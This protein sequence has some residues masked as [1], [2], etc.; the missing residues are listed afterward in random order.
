MPRFC[1]RSTCTSCSTPFSTSATRD[2]IG[3]IL[4]RISSLM[5]LSLAR[6][7]GK[8]G[9]AYLQHSPATRNLLTVNRQRLPARNGKFFEQ[10][11]GFAEGQAHYRRIT[12]LQLADEHRRQPLNRVTAS[13]VLGLAA[14]PVGGDFL[15]AQRAKTH[16]AADH[17]HGHP[18][19]AGQGH[20]R[21]GTEYHGIQWLT[22]RSQAGL[23]FRPGQTLY[24]GDWRL[25]W[26]WIFINGDDLAKKGH[27]NL[28][29]QFTSTRR[30]GCQIERGHA[31]FSLSDK[32]KARKPCSID[33]NALLQPTQ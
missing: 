2:S 23:R 11:G 31:D 17:P 28:R 6:R 27:A 20:G 15:G 22:Q 26:Q 5:A 9:Y 32:R 18:R 3:V 30:T 24:I 29:Q 16:L 1:V 12:A 19:R 13:L 21:I 8:P 4:I 25:I 33:A 7:S 14:G 10:L